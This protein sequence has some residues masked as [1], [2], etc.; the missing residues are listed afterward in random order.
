MKQ[1]ETKTD[2][3]LCY[4]F[5]L[6]TFRNFY[7]QS[8]VI[9]NEAPFYFGVAGKGQEKKSDGPDGRLVIVEE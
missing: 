1:Y 2:E 6:L 8:L 3:Q 7:D 9:C 4:S 5:V